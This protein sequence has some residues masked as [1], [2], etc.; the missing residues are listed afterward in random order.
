MTQIMD[1]NFMQVS[2]M[3]LDGNY[4]AEEVS[5]MTLENGME[6]C[7]A[8][9]KCSMENIVEVTYVSSPTSFAT[10]TIQVSDGELS[11]LVN[12]IKNK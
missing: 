8:K 12:F 2:G 1:G 10:K 6:C 4:M 5:Y 11:R 3:S 9:I 7:N